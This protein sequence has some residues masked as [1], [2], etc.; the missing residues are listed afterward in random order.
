MVSHKFI[1]CEIINANEA[2]NISNAKD[3]SEHQGGYT[4]SIDHIMYRIR[5]H[6]S[7]GYTGFYIKAYQIDNEVIEKL[8]SLGYTLEKCISHDDIGFPYDAYHI[9]WA[10]D[11]FEDLEKQMKDAF[12]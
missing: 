1:G 8:E 10:G 4:K 7:E 11:M 3:N 6:A 2:L 12:K 9:S 5:I